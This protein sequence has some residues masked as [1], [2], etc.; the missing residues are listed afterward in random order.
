MLGS[1]PQL[2]D[3]ILPLENSEKKDAWTGALAKKLKCNRDQIGEMRL[4]KHSIDA[5]KKDIK[6]RL[7]LEV[8]AKDTT[9]SADPL[10]AKLPYFTTR[11]LFGYCRGS[12]ARRSFRSPKTD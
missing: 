6:V 11:R 4:R 3:I 7:R 10:P 5:R 1:S 2:V 8:V 9:W 12:R